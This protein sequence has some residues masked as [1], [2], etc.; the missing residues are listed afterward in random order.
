[1]PPALLDTLTAEEVEDLLGFLL[2]GGR[3]AR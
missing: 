3:V 1:M 2:A